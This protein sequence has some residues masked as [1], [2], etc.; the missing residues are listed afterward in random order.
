MGA[1]IGQ[2]RDCARSSVSGAGENSGRSSGTAG[3]VPLIP[4]FISNSYTL[5]STTFS[6]ENQNISTLS[7][8]CGGNGG[9]G[10]Q[11]S[12]AGI[13][14]LQFRYGVYTDVNTLQPSRF[15]IASE[16]AAL[17]NITVDGVDKDAWARV[18]SVEVCLVARAMQQTKTTSST[19]TVTPYLDCSGASV[20]PND[21][22]IRRVYRK[23]FALR[24]NLTQIIAPFN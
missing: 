17:G 12:I 18:V 13:E 10:Y 7:L 19:G 8:T 3:Q 24:N 23:V 22:A 11:P 5:A 21:R 15:Y 9:A 6:I 1:D 20:S 14:N 4:L 2:Q 16:M